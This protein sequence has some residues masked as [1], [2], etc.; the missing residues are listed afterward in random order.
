MWTVATSYRAML[1]AF[2]GARRA[3]LMRKLLRRARPDPRDRTAQLARQ[4]CEGASTNFADWA[5]QRDPA[6]WEEAELFARSLRRHAQSRL[7]HVSVR[8]GGGGA[9]DALYFVTR[10]VKPRHVLETGV[11]AGWSSAAFLAA[12][13]RNGAGHLYSSDLPYLRRPGA[14]EH[15]GLLVDAQL[16]GRWTL[17]TNGDRANLELILSK[18]QSFDI[19]HYDSDKSYSEREYFFRRIAPCL[20]DGSVVMFDDVSDNLHFRDLARKRGW[21]AHVFGNGSKYFGM[22]M[23]SAAFHFPVVKRTLNDPA[24]VIQLNSAALALV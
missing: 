23:I 22:A 24:L 15:I 14:E 2:L 6:L 1:G 19:V 10:L 17:H 18:C 4:W 7:A 8:M 21:K 9:I 5:R 11:A 16:R 13:E 3:T 12:M 20:H